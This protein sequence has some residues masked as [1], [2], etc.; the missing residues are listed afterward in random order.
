MEKSKLS[1]FKQILE[2]RKIAI[3]NHLN[4]NVEEIESLHNSEPSDNVDFSSINT[5]SQI[6]QTINSNLKLELSEIDIALAKIKD[7][8]YGI[9]ESCNDDI[10]I[11]RLKIKPHAR[12]CINCRENFEKERKY[13]N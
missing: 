11:E 12:Y 13:E 9:C 8:E 10:H 5:S 6:E 4:V 2:D 1:F 3:Y 7:G